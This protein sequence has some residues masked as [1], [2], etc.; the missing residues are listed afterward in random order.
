MLNI[1]VFFFILTDFTSSERAV[2]F[3]IPSNISVCFYLQSCFIKLHVTGLFWTYAVGHTGAELP[4]LFA[5]H[6]CKEECSL[7]PC[8]CVDIL[9]HQ[10][11]TC[12]SPESAEWMCLEIELSLCSVPSV[13]MQSLHCM[14][15]APRWKAALR[16]NKTNL[17]FQFRSEKEK[18]H[19]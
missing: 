16:K 2:L 13:Q 4:T 14:L 12:K 18:N 9:L 3:V 17:L 8:F 6:S 7:L 19:E 5:R 11:K 10:D 1:S 15:T